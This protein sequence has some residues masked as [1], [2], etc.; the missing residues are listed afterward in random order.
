MHAFLGGRLRFLEIAE[1]IE[2]TLDAAA[3]ASR[4]HSFD[5]LAD[6]DARRPQASP[7]SSSTARASSLKSS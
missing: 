6:A 1:V 7:A 3:R 4:S 2:E 5:S